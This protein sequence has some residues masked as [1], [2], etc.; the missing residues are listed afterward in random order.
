VQKK[1]SD[2]KSLVF[3]ISQTILLSNHVNVPVRL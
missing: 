1:K 3:L 2:L